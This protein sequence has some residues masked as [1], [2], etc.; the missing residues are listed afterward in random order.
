MQ[1]TIGS[2]CG[3]TNFPLPSNLTIGPQAKEGSTY[4][5]I[6]QERAEKLE[7]ATTAQSECKE[8]FAERK[9]RVTASQF[10][11]IIKRKKDVN[12]KFLTRLFGP[13]RFSNEATEYGL[14]HE[15][16][17]RKEYL[18]Q[19]PNSHA[20][21]CGLVVNPQFSFIGASPDNK[22]CENGNTGLLEIKCPFNA[23]AKTME[24]A[25]ADIPGFF[26]HHEN[27]N[28]KLKRADNYY[29]Q[30]Q[31]QLLV[32]GAPFCDFIVWS[33]EGSHI[34]RILPDLDMHQD[35]L[36]RLAE[37]YINHAMDFLKKSN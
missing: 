23:R 20:H 35:M 24:E 28:I 17:A 26:L 32:T 22:I 33:K 29:Y 10:G 3:N 18:R 30:V 14:R 25:I 19:R 37:F 6:S 27:E 21:E 16:D 2:D 5:P 36:N 15:P 34:E 7:Q 13:K 1:L 8:W 12:Q 11:D 4:L 31:G 9:L